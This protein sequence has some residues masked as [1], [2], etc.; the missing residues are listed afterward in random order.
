MFLSLLAPF[1]V[2]ILI[3]CL[4][5]IISGSSSNETISNQ[6]SFNIPFSKDINYVITSNYGYRDDP[7]IPS[8][9]RFHQGI[10]LSAPE[11]T[12]ILASASGKVIEVG[13]R[14]AGLGNYVQIKHKVKNKSYITLYAHMLDNSILVS[15]GQTIKGGQKI[16][17]IGST[18][19]STGIHLHFALYSSNVV[20]G[21][22]NKDPSFIFQ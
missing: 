19:R 12:F 7:L 6:D 14:D 5:M 9:N 21:V 1:S 17:I 11:G 16:G 8:E 10:D 15:K 22:T 2:L 3:M 4:L 18:G 13:I 20:Y